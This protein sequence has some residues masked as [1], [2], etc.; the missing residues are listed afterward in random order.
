MSFDLF[1]NSKIT[2]ST[3][4]PYFDAD[5]APYFEHA[6]VNGADGEWRARQEGAGFAL[7]LTLRQASDPWNTTG[8]PQYKWRVELRVDGR[9][10]LHARN[11]PQYLM[12]RKSLL[13]TIA[14]AWRKAA[15]ADLEDAKNILI[16]EL[17]ARE[18]SPEPYI[19]LKY[20]HQLP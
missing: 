10:V 11:P 1:R 20:K 7:E 8:W 12:M 6:E 3:S 9:S 17:R 16:R 4:A 18:Q 13:L 15:S 5:V 14:D 19:V 2:M